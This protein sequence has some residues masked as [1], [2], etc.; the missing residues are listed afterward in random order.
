MSSIL[1]VITTFGIAE[2][3]P[4]MARPATEAAGDGT[5]AMTTQNALKTAVLIT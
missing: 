5:A 4:V 3:K 1:P 2:A